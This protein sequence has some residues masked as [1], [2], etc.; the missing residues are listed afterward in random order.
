MTPVAGEK[1]DDQIVLVGQ[2]LEL[3]VSGRLV[4]A[5]GIRVNGDRMTVRVRAMDAVNITAAPD[6][7][8][9]ITKLQV[10]AWPFETNLTAHGST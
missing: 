6:G 7:S 3:A 5:E 4:S 2:R 9:A 10:T 8:F 1:R